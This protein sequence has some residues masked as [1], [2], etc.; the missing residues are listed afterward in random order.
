MPNPVYSVVIPCYN[1]EAVLRE[2]FRRLSAVMEGLDGGYELVFVNDAS[3]DG[4]GAVLNALCDEDSHVRVVHFARNSGH[5]IAVSAGIDYATGKAI[6]II[7]AD[8]QDPPELIPAMADRWRAGIQVVYGKRRSRAGES[9]FK[10]WTAS[11]YYRLVRFFAGTAFPED[12]GDFRLVDR[13]V[14][15]AVRAM[16]ES[17]RYLRGMFAWV[18][19]RQEA[20]LYDREKRFAGKTHYSLRKMLKL[21]SDGIVSFSGKPLAFAFWT[22]LA[23][24]GVGLGAALVLLFLSKRAVGLWWLAA[25][26][27]FLAG[28]ILLALGISGAYLSRV[29]D[30]A[31]QR[32][33]YIVADTRGFSDPPPGGDITG[34]ASS[35]ERK[36]R[37]DHHETAHHR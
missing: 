2:T 33:L 5:Q 17:N 7:D 16:P 8:L 34:Q 23:W 25:L 9:V 31:K 15:D 29:Y 22:G 28:N 12:T 37:H 32:P 35:Y 4:T 18:G 11:L 1:E 30:E 36:Q 6:I 26:L 19:F 10:K 13:R 3:S 14:A 21:A 24:M 27:C 20:I